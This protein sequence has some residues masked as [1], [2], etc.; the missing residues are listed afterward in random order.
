MTMN[1]PIPYI[2]WSNDCMRLVLH[3]YN[4]AD[5]LLSGF[6][7]LYRNSPYLLRELVS[8]FRRSL[9]SCE[10]QWNALEWAACNG[11]QHERLRS[12]APAGGESSRLPHWTFV[13][14]LQWTFNQNTF[15]SRKCIWKCHLVKW[16]P[17]C[18][19]GNELRVQLTINYWFR[20]THWG[21]ATHICVGNLTIIGW[22]Y[23]LSP[24]RRQAIIST[25]VGILSIGPLG[26]NFY[27][28]SIGI[29]TF[30]FK[31]MHFNMSSAK[32]CLFCLGLNVL[33]S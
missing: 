17:F 4:P 20:L 16:Q 33:T 21:R 1:I 11:W 27:E 9:L 8:I 19:G 32:R 15:H 24:G 14:K 7:M 2:S 12:L 3:K 10:R 26:T 23:G 30:S 25:T 29:Q 28:I 22:D 18:P 31:K 5:H 6:T 13:N